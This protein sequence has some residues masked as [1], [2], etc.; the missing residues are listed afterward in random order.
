MRA[1]IVVLL[2]AIFATLASGLVFLIR[3]R[4]DSARTAKALT[5]RIGLSILLFVVVLVLARYTTR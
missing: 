2:I 3:D 1:L 4:N 5:W